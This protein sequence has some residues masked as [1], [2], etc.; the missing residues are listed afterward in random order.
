[1]VRVDRN[2]NILEYAH[3][4]KLDINS[5]I[6]TAATILLGILTIIV[7]FYP[8]NQYFDFVILDSSTYAF[9]R[10]VFAVIVLIFSFI[11]LYKKTITEGIL[12]LLSGVSSLIFVLSEIS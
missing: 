5:T 3:Y 11:A 4:S 6:P 2:I 9:T 1:M 7:G 12:L 10:L 8:L